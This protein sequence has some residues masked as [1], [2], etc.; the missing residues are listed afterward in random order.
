MYCFRYEVLYLF[1]VG[2]VMSVFIYV[3]SYVFL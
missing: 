2:I 1:M 3:F